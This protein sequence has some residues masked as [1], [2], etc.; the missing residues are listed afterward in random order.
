MLQ[1]GIVENTGSTARDYAMMER[2]LLSHLKLAILLSLLA[3]S[4]LL[5]A[6]LVPQDERTKQNGGIPMASVE[7]AA[8]LLC[9][10]AGGWEYWQNYQD[11]R[12]QRAFLTA[13]KFHDTIMAVVAATVFGTCVALLIW[14]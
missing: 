4:V 3:S 9:I 7:F 10:A 1:G 5:R 8:A 6:R 11:L 14:E 12:S 2:N 13:P